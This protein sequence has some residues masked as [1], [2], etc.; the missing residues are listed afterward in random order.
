[1]AK[2][3]SENE[4]LHNEREHL[5]KT[6]TELYDSIKP[7]RVHAKEQCDSLIAN[8]NS[9]SME[10]AYL[11]TQ[12]QEKIF[13]NAALKNELRKLKGKNVID[14]AVSKSYA[15]TI[16]PGMFKLNLEPL[17]PKVLKNKNAH[18]EYI[19]HSRE[20]AGIL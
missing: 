18:L 10:N 1:M 14:T 3:L 2:L 8:L 4:K 6:Y 11:K 19:K 12:I 13:A 17:A 20:H 15:T 16:S 5:K 9:K 7:S